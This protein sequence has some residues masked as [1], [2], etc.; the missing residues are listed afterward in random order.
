MFVF[1]FDI[2]QKLFLLILLF[3]LAGVLGLCASLTHLYLSC[4]SIAPEG[5]DSLAGV[6]VQCPA[7]THLLLSCNDI[8]VGG[9]ESLA[10]VLAQCP[11]LDYLALQDHDIGAVGK[12][13]LRASWRG[14]A[15]AHTL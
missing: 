9:A 15:S 2:L 13:R 6:L 10:G 12:E 14:Q 8:G 7:L 5:A 3:S 4:S 1:L 11:A